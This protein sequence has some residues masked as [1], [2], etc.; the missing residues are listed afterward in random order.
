MNPTQFEVL[1]AYVPTLNKEIITASD[2]TIDNG[3]LNLMQGAQRV[4]SYPVG[5]WQRVMRRVN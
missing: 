1:I 2:Y 4:A 5:G 3:V